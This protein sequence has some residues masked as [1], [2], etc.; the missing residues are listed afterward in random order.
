[1]PRPLHVRTTCCVLAALLPRPVLIT[2]RLASP[3]ALSLSHSLS[4]SLP[5]RA[6]EHQGRKA[7]RHSHRRSL[8][9]STPGGHSSTSPAP[10]H[11]RRASLWGP[12]TPSA[13]LPWPSPPLTFR[14]P[15]PGRHSPPLA[16]HAPLRVRAG[17]GMLVRC[18]LP[19][20]RSHAGQIH[21]FESHPLLALYEGRREGKK[22]G[23]RVQMQ[24]Q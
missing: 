14:L 15:W 17:P 21:D 18:P 4:L 22:M 16:S 19:P 7:E 12:S 6:H 10:S 23:S 3:S 24:S 1:M 2:R 20:A 5:R 13:S 8:L 9:P 11:V